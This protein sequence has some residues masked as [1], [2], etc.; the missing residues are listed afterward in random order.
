MLKLSNIVKSFPSQSQPT[1]QGITVHLEEGE[2]CVVLGNNGSGKST[3]F[4]TLSGELQ[5]DQGNITLA[6]KD[7]SSLPIHQRAALISSV[8]QETN[9]GTILEM[10]LLENM[11]LAMLRG[12]R[13]RYSSLRVHQK[14]AIEAVAS[15]ELQLEHRL[16]DKLSLLSGGQRQ[17]IATLMALLT[18]PQ[19]LL[20][21]EHTSAL[22]P[23]TQTALMTF[24]ARKI[25]EKNITT[26]MITHHLKQALT[27]GNRLI[28]LHQGKILMDLKGKE[29]SNMSP[30]KLL[31][32]FYANKPMEKCHAYI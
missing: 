23:K 26:L 27:Y 22:D 20:L 21:D 11:V 10:S 24:T 12:K 7:I 29:K 9:T 8:T 19:L 13:S 18:K 30:E 5:I 28:M 3:L 15:L 31:S 2:F 17:I 6:N 14:L 1:L 25:K 16:H 32:Y 4:K